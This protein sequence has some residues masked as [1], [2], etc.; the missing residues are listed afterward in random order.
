MST[1]ISKQKRD[2][3]LDKI[4]QIKNFISAGPQDE[5]TANLLTYI[6]ELTKEI[7]GKKYGLVFEEHREK[8]DELL[9]ENAPVLVE[10]EDLFIDNGGEM[11]FLIEGDNLAALKLLEKTHKGKIDVIYIDPP[12]NTGDEDFIYDD[13]YVDKEDVFRHSKW[14]SFMEKRLE[15]AKTLL[16]KDGVIFISIDDNEQSQIKILCDEIFGE[17]NF[18]DNLMVEMSNTGGMKVGAAKKGSITKNGEF[19]LIYQK[20]N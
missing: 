7:N 15:V 11:N 10:Q 5:N 8:I 14:L 20:R 2:A 19:I 3:L 16:K 13:N 1:N 18:V 12:Y 6:G 17:T 4:Q 9:E